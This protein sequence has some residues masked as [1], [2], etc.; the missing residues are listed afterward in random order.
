[1]IKLKQFITI[2]PFLLFFS[3]YKL[4]LPYET[5]VS[6]TDLEDPDAK[7][8]YELF[9]GNFTDK[10][11]PLIAL[12]LVGIAFY[13]LKSPQLNLFFLALAYF[14]YL[15][16]ESLYLYGSFFIYPH[17]F[18]KIIELFVV[19]AVY[20]FYS[21]QQQVNLHLMMNIF[22]IV[23]FL[24]ILV[25][26]E[27]VSKDAFV[28]HQRGIDAP[29]AYILMLPALF[30]LNY[31]FVESKTS[32]L[33][34]ASILLFF[35]F[36]FQHRTVWVCT[37]FALIVNFWLLQK[38]GIV[39]VKFVLP[40][41]IV[42]LV[43]FLFLFAGISSYHPDVLLKVEESVDQILNPQNEGT[44]SDWRIKQMEAY[45][46]FVMDNLLVG[47]RLRGFDLPMQYYHIEAGSLIFQD[48]TGHHFHSF[49]F[50]KLFYFGLLGLLIFMI[51]FIV[52]LI[53]LFKYNLFLDPGRIS[54]VTFALSGFLY[55]LSYDLPTYFYAIFGFSMVFIEDRYKQKLSEDL[56][57][58]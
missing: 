32:A 53:K 31:Y 15:V 40:R 29:S 20:I 25:S 49:Y 57:A 10:Y 5:I 28:A 17:V 9:I 1:M 8:S 54:F 13:R 21:K 44:T 48:K 2:I 24:K 42:G 34:K 58:T 36:F 50:D 18:L 19:L 6:N 41:M 33:I 47:M 37:V 22:L 16:F 27:I 26:P 14:I 56:K 4:F 30:F 11:L 23:L 43:I 39:N 45:L 3:S 12:G 7:S 35:I 55:G 46:P 38:Q 51:F 52:P